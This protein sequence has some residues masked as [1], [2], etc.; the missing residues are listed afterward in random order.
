[1]TRLPTRHWRTTSTPSPP[2]ATTHTQ[3]WTPVML[4]GEE[5]GGGGGGGGGGRRRCAK[6]LFYIFYLWSMRL[7]TSSGGRI[8]SCGALE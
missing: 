1:M 7:W 4:V 6:G 8:L 3:M 2:L 5:A